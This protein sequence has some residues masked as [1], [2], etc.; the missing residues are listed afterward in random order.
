M[1]A[2]FSPHPVDKCLTN[3]CLVDQKP[4]NQ[5]LKI[6]VQLLFSLFLT[7]IISNLACAE[8]TK[9]NNHDRC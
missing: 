1:P 7:L 2:Y 5:F 9:P 3:S 6:G 8:N 4:L